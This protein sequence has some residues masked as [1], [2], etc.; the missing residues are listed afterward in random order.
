VKPGDSLGRMFLMNPKVDDLV[1]KF[2][3][4][5]IHGITLMVLGTVVSGGSGCFCPENALLRSL[6]KYL[7]LKKDEIVIIDM[8]AGVEHLG[9]STAENVDCL[10][11]VVEPSVKSIEIAGQI[12]RLAGDIGIRKIVAVLNKAT[13]KQERTR[14]DEMLAALGI[15][16]IGIIPKD[17]CIAKADFEGVSPFSGSGCDRLL[18]NIR[19]IKDALETSPS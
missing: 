9:R 5:C 11:V 3:I 14:V 12:K 15:P 10:V 4:E 18:E 7:V 8:E 6:M 2:G 1:D 13:R 19:R 16:L 17:D